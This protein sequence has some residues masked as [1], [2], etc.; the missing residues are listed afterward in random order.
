LNNCSI[1]EYKIS[2]LKEKYANNN[3]IVNYID[4]DYGPGTKLLGLF[5]N[6]VIEE[7]VD[8]NTYII[9]I[10]DDL[11]YQPYM[12]EEFDKY[13][14]TNNTIQVASFFA[15]DY[16]NIKIAQGAD[17]FLIKYNTLSKFLQY[18]NEI[19]TEDYVNYHDDYFI[20][21]YFYLLN[22]PIHYIQPPNNCYI[23]TVTSTNQ[24]DSLMNITDNYNRNNLGVKI[25][26]IFNKLN[27]DNKFSFLTSH[28]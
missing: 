17:G 6:N 4:N 15:Y 13:L 26:E 2:N 28:S 10:D 8:E 21:Y 25:T 18:Y 14:S 16:N 23:Y 3:I 24:I 19:K 22:I 1:E 11:Y 27:N 20:S 12:I 5:H 7:F 9:L